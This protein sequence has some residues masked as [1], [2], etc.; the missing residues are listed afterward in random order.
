[1]PLQTTARLTVTSAERD[2]VNAEVASLTARVAELEAQLAAP[3]GRLRTSGRQ[4]IRASGAAFLPRGVELMYDDTAASNPTH[5]CSIVAGWGANTISPLFKPAQR[6]AASINAF[7]NAARAANLVVGFNAD[8]AREDLGQD[9]S[10]NEATRAWL[11]EPAIVAACNGYPDLFLEIEVELGGV[12]DAS[13]V[14]AAQSLINRLRS[15]GHVSVIKLGSGAGGRDPSHAIR[16]AA[17]LTDPAGPGYLAYTCQAYYERVVS[18]WS[19]QGDVLQPALIPTAA[20]PGCAKALADRLASSNLPFLVGLDREDDVGVTLYAELAPELKRVGL[21]WQWWV[22]TGDFR[23]AN[24]LVD[25][26]LAPTPP[27]DTATVVSAL[28]RAV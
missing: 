10:R 12:T 19:Y 2:R 4:F 28:L 22:L 17:Q 16:N 13:W 1:M 18:G 24:N 25:W 11:C 15:A 3:P 20:D 5:V 23:S 6:N 27:K 7:L 8:H 26:D 9:P 14:T 21:G